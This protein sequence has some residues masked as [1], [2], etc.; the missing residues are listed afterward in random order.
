[1]GDWDSRRPGSSGN[2]KN[3]RY[4][5][6]KFPLLFLL[7]GVDFVMMYGCMRSSGDQSRGSIG[8]SGI[9]GVDICMHNRTGNQVYCIK[10]TEV[11]L[12]A[13]NTVVLSSLFVTSQIYNYFIVS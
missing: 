4:S 13:R 10:S 2:G 11:S 3:L 8:H 7:A 6:P 5:G 12:E 1:M 9:C